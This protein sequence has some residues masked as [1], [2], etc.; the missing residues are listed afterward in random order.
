LF[1]FRWF[2][3][4]AMVELGARM[5]RIGRDAR[6]MEEAARRA[7]DCLYEGFADAASGESALVLARL[8]KTHPHGALEAGQQEFADGVSK[9]PCEPDVPCLTL[10]ATR[11][12]EPDWNSR[13]RSRAH[14]AL[15]LR[16]R[17]AVES[18]PMIAGLLDQL[19]VDVDAV[20]APGVI[21]MDGQ[22]RIESFNAAA[23]RLFDLGRSEAVGR[24]VASLFD[25]SGT[26]GRAGRAPLSPADLLTARE[27]LARDRRGRLFPVEIAVREVPE[28]LGRRTFVA[29]VRDLTLQKQ[30]EDKIQTLAYYDSLTA[31]PN[32]LLFQDRL[33]KAVEWARFSGSELALLFLDLDRFKEV[34]DV[35]GHG[36]GDRVLREV[37]ERLLGCIRGND[38]VSRWEPDR[39]GSTLARIGGDEFTVLLSRIARG[40]DAAYVARRILEALER[41]LQ[42]DGREV[43]AE[44]SIGIAV[45]PVDGEDAETLLRNADAAMYHAKSRGRNR[46]EFYSASMNAEVEEKLRLGNALRNALGRGE[47]YL[48]YQPIRST[49]HAVLS[50]VEALLRWRHPERGAVPPAVFVPIAEETGLIGPIGDWVLREACAQA[51]RWEGQGLRVPRLSVNV[52]PHQLRRPGWG[53]TVADILGEFGLHAGRLEMELTE[54]AILTDDEVTMANLHRIHDCGVDLTLDDFG[55]GYSSLSCLRRVPLRRVKIERSFVRDVPGDLADETLVT[56]IA[57]LAHSLGLRVVAEGVETRE[58]AEFLAA[59]GCDE[60]QG[61]LFARPS[62]PEALARLLEREKPAGDVAAP[63]PGARGTPRT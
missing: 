8:Y 47:L 55:T 51:G 38:M 30:A 61:H 5:R 45:H 22:G 11:G 32:R 29:L 56:A 35:Y 17:R 44:A 31:L 19:G 50:G 60:L 12:D 53:D 10:L 57:G 6:S 4:S 40:A 37:A 43:Y 3:M 33:R 42:I 18:A 34:N 59:R 49:R 25:D 54:T 7:T 21:S 28:S 46:F 27:L 41:P 9:E 36:A 16:S 63:A 23:S 58:Q 62:S 15:P 2:T 52:S 26:P 20:L 1:D 39:G 14:Q 48:E 24:N 13:H